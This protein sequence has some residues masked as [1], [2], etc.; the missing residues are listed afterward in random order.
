[1][2]LLG[3]LVVAVVLFAVLAR[4]KGMKLSSSS[5]SSVWKRRVEDRVCFP[6]E[7]SFCSL[8]ESPLMESQWLGGR[9]GKGTELVQAEEGQ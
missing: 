2:L 7:K 8:D 9:A 1:M 6:H 3:L 4:K 5:S